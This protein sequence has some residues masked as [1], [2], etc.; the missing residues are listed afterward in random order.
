MKNLVMTLGIILG[1][2]MFL[3][4]VQVSAM[5]F[6]G[7]GQIESGIVAFESIQGSIIRNRDGRNITAPNAVYPNDRVARGEGYTL[8]INYLTDTVPDVVSQQQPGPNFFKVKVVQVVD[9]RISET[10]Y[11]HNY[12][13]YNAVFSWSGTVSMNPAFRE[14][15]FK[16]YN[17]QG[18]LMQSIRLPIGSY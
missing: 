6:S 13:K 3:N 8:R 18:R 10:R 7:L 5:G 16:I 11:Y 2:V 12:T 17:D 9:G 15:Y 14:V 1:L 4:A